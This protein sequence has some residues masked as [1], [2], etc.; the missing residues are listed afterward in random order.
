MKDSIKYVMFVKKK[1]KILCNFIFVLKNKSLSNESYFPFAVL[2]EHIFLLIVSGN[3][4]TVIN[5]FEIKDELQ[6]KPFTFQA[7]K[8]YHAGQSLGMITMFPNRVRF[9]RIII[10]TA[11]WEACKVMIPLCR[12]E[13]NIKQYFTRSTINE[14]Q[15]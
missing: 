12:L 7:Q 14:I 13:L 3:H 11:S 4:C 15:N 5:Q 8:L 2:F 6:V 10:I 1:K 9:S